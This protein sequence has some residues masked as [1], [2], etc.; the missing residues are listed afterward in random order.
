[1]GSEF[2]AQV[3]VLRL[4]SHLPTEINNNGTSLRGRGVKVRFILH[5]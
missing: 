2:T 4:S 3:V 1:M 5:G